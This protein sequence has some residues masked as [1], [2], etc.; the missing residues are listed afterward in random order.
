MNSLHTFLVKNRAKNEQILFVVEVLFVLFAV[1]C[2]YQLRMQTRF[3]FQL[4]N[5]GLIAGQVSIGLYILTLL[6]GIAQRLKLWPKWTAVALLYRRH[7]GIMMFLAALF[8]YSFVLMLRVLFFNIQIMPTP[9]TIL[10]F[11]GLFVLFPLW[12]T[13][14]DPAQ[15]F[16]GRNWKRLHRLTYVALLLLFGHVAVQSSFWLWPMA[17]VIGLEAWS[18]RRFHQ[19][20]QPKNVS[21]PSSKKELAS[22]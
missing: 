1:W 16:L 10:G 13:S 5:L 19:S 8:H 22:S 12:L 7:L 15:R 3:S 21:T 20:Q 9:V 2:A 6:P 14:N 18:W 11:F 4:Y 17:V